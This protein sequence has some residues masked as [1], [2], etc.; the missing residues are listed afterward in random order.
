MP[1][2]KTEVACEMKKILFAKLMM[3]MLAALTAAQSNGDRCHVYLVDVA[4][5]QK[6]LDAF[7]ESGNDE[8]DAKTLSVGQTVFPEFR[9]VVGEEELT[10][11]NYRFPGSRLMITASVFYTDE[12]MASSEGQ[13][14][15][16]LGIVVSPRSHPNALSEPNNAMAELTSIGSDTA[17][18]K[19]YLKVNGRLFLVGIECRRKESKPPH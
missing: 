16:V 14:S 10:T 5:A 11:K 13:D 1:L 6:T 4:R 3:L 19:K 15:M 8:A 2:A 9:T 7:R 12:S 18:A 17:R